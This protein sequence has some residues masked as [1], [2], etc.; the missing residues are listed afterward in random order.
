[1]SGVPATREA[2]QKSYY[3]RA[4]V[5]AARA[6]WG[7]AGVQDAAARMPE[8]ERAEFF[9]DRL[10][11]WAPTRAMIAWNF[12][13]WE[14]PVRR[15]K[16]IYFSWVRKTADLSFGRVRRL[17]LSMA[18]PEKLITSASDLWKADHTAGTLDGLVHGKCG[19]LMLRDHPYTETPQARTAIA[20]MMR[21]SV[22][23]TRARSPT[24]THALVGPRAMQI[25]VRWL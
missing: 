7:E 22:E 15:D 5:D 8:R 4:A 1:M 18:T 24:A 2:S 17:F 3:F 23:L 11:E 21:Y 16:A 14:G 9:A 12:A 13:L 6:I 25:K 10:P 19:T 20:E